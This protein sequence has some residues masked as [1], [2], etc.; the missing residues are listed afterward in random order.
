MSINLRKNSTL[1]S[2]QIV[3]D[4]REIF[5]CPSPRTFFSLIVEEREKETEKH[6]LADFSDVPPTWDG[7]YNLGVCP[8]WKSNPRPFSL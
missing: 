2:K 8:E 3:T 5:Y 1:G 6:W 7:I 4:A